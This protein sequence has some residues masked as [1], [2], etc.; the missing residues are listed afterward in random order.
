VQISNKDGGYS[1][2]HLYR[3][4]AHAKDFRNTFPI[5]HQLEEETY[6]YAEDIFKKTKEFIFKA[7]QIGQ[8]YL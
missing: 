5:Y 4:K 7:N 8:F 2:P 6:D 1:F 3:L